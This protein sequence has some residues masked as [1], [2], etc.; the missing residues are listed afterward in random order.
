GSSLGM[1]PLGHHNYQWTLSEGLRTTLLRF[2]SS[3]TLDFC[4]F[5]FDFQCPPALP[6]LSDSASLSISLRLLW[7]DRRLE[8][9]ET[10][11]HAA[12]MSRSKPFLEVPSS[13]RCPR[14][15]VFTLAGLHRKQAC[16]SPADLAP[17]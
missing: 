15:G 6:S 3:S 10:S 17:S 4:L 7:Y 16:P 12:G 5:V 14:L 9:F 2:P 11:G 8:S 1:L 13:T